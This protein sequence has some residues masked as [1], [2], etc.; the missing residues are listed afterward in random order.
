M[1]VLILIR[2]DFVTPFLVGDRVVFKVKHHTLNGTVIFQDECSVSVVD[3]NGRFWNVHHK[4]V[5]PN[6]ENIEILNHK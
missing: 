1:M 5:F 2:R 6:K 3:E 4:V